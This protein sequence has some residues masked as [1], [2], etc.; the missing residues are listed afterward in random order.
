MSARTV[1]AFGAH[2]AAQ[3]RPTPKPVDIS[4]RV[5]RASAPA[6]T[7]PDAATTADTSEASSVALRGAGELQRVTRARQAADERLAVTLTL[8]ELRDLVRDAALESIVEAA[9]VA[10]GAP[11][12]A[13]LDRAGLARALSLG[14]STVARL[15]REGMPTI[16]VGDSPRFELEPCLAWLRGRGQP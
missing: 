16:L 9:T 12:P 8:G 10:D 11:K 13:L 5:R 2:C 4:G 15:R 6:Q 1:R 14:T 3:G 7:R